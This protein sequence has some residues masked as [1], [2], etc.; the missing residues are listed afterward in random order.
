VRTYLGRHGHGETEV[1]ALLGELQAKGLVDDRR[2]AEWFVQA[3]RGRRPAG[4][5]RIVRELTGRGVPRPMAENAVRAQDT[6]AEAELQRALAAAGPRFASV[7]RLGRE[8]GLRR[9]HA[10]LVR[11]GFGAGVARRACLQLFAG[12]QAYPADPVSPATHEET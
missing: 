1:Q 8:R 12:V 4:T 2:Y 11:R 7:A 5:A 10:F 9:L 3:R 6:G